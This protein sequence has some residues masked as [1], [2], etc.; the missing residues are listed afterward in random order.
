MYKIIIK[1]EASTDYEDLEKLDGVDCQEEFSEYFGSK[2]GDNNN[3]QAL[4]DKGV[5]NGY[6]QFSYE[7]RKLFT[8][9]EY[10]SREELTKEELD[11]LASYTQGQWSDGIGEGFEQYPCMEDKEGNEVY[12]SPWH[13]GQELII[14][15]SKTK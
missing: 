14:T 2:Y 12:I 3:E 13:P 9:T 11:Q 5:E 1:G 6:M 4:I 8:I 15:Q 10:E 7:N